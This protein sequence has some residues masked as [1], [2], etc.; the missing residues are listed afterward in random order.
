MNVLVYVNFFVVH[1]LSK[2]KRQKRCLNL[3]KLEKNSFI[4]PFLWYVSKR[5]REQS[6]LVT[7]SIPR[8]PVYYSNWG[9]TPTFLLNRNSIWLSK[10]S[11][12][13]GHVVKQ[14]EARS[15]RNGIRNIYIILIR[16]LKSRLQ[17]TLQLFFLWFSTV[18]FR[19]CTK[20]IYGN[21]KKPTWF[22]IVEN[23][24]KSTVLLFHRFIKRKIFA[25]SN[26]IIFKYTIRT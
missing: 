17:L 6:L 19:S 7:H 10:I 14:C 8:V 5:K 3:L 9:Y 21:V 23:I 20:Y 18:N 25:K 26:S 12:L 22:D 1:V 24:Q 15:M 16:L 2:Y 4:I 11:N 13:V